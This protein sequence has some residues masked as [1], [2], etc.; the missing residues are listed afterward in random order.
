M[1]ERWIRDFTH[2]ARSLARAP[3]F[4]LVVVV[5]L[6]LAIGANTAIFSV[7]DAVLLEPLPFPHADRLVDIAGTAPGTDQPA[8]FGVPDELYFEYREHVDGLEDIGLYGTG[9]STTRAE[10]QVDQLFVTQATPSFF[11]TLGAQPLHGRLPT[12]EDGSRVVVI[13]HWLWRTWFGSDVS[14]INKSYTFANETRTVIGVMKPEFRFPD[15]RVA[16]WVP[17]TIR[18]A[19]VTPGGFGPRAVA[20]MKPGTDRAALVA[21]L[22]PLA[23]RVQ[24][25][26]GGPAPYVRIMERHRPVVKPLRAHLLGNI[27][28]P[29]WIL[30]GTVGI[31]FL[32]ACA[33]VA[34]LFTVRAE[35]RR[36]DLA[37]RRALGA[38]RSDLVR[39]LVTEALLLAAAGGAAGALIAWAGVPLLVRSA[40]D[41]VAGG[42]GGAPIPGLGAASLDLT[43]TVL[44]DRHVGRGGVCVRSAAS[45]P[46]LRL[47]PWHPSSRRTRHRRRE[48]DARCTGDRT[49]R[50][51]ARPA[52]WVGA[53]H[54]QLLATR[55]RRCRIRHKRDLHVSGR[56]QSSRPQRPVRD[57]E[58]PVRV[59]GSPEG[60][61]GRRIR[62]LHHDAPSGR[63]RRP[64]E[65]HHVQA[66]GERRRGAGRSL[67]GRRG[68]VL[69]DDGHRAR[70]RPL[71]RAGRGRTGDA[72]CD[73]Q[74]VGRPSCCFQARIRS[75]SSC[76][77]RP[78]ASGG[79]ASSA[80]SRTS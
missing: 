46:R 6:A 34:S 37:V 40:P 58:V 32:I 21:Q 5:T 15:E 63:G 57:V 59:H 65:H 25:R 31:V 52:R 23:R 71:L 22:E 43:G 33:N 30:L 80:W 29:L 70:A 51:R 60:A 45:S 18:A 47:A 7:V 77:P 79:T 75:T 54:A 2:A 26:L 35:N 67:R 13:S 16:F 49:D 1:L 42:F 12:D 27:S 68:R 19:Q 41:A 50:F 14:V 78:V 55:Q 62:R 17:Q 69:S 38:G 44:H 4:T 36:R 24:Q 64:P 39:S 28:T 9:S 8:E 73:H 74:R 10:G 3:G 66:R 48:P 53:A 56:G 20:R 11:T 72:V 76:G 61:P